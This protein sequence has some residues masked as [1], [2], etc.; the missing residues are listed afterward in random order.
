MQRMR[1][2]NRERQ[3]TKRR[4][5]RIARWVFGIVVVVC[6]LLVV[7]T[8]ASFW[9]RLHALLV[10]T[11]WMFLVAAVMGQRMVCIGY[12]DLRIRPV[13]G[14]VS[15]HEGDDPSQVGL[16]GQHLQVEH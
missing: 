5:N 14:F 8:V 6:V 10:L 7:A 1:D 12:A 13:A 3:V 11:I 16:I 9:W 15:D 2:G 4:H